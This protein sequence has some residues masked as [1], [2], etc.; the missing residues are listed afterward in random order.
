MGEVSDAVADQA[1]LPGGLCFG[2]FIPTADGATL[3]RESWFQALVWG[4]EHAARALLSMWPVP[5][6]MTV[7]AAARRPA[8]YAP[9]SAPAEVIQRTRAL[10]LAQRSGGHERAADPRFPG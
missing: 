9:G 2:R 4:F 3:V 10:R 5:I 1:G 6:R 8:L 7:V